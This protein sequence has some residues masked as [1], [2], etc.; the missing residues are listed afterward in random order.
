MLIDREAALLKTAPG[1]V[2]PLRLLMALC[3]MALC[4]TTLGVPANAAARKPAAEPRQ[5][6]VRPGPAA[7]PNYV[8]PGGGRVFR[9]SSAPGGWRTDH[10]DPPSPRDPSRFGGG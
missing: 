7:N 5:A 10:D 1:A 6:I 8:A 2:V 9:D 4:V 3:L